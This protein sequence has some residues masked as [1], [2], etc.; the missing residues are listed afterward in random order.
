MP[1]RAYQPCD[2]TTS[3]PRGVT[4]GWWKKMLAFDIN[5]RG[6]TLVVTWGDCEGNQWQWRAVGERI[7]EGVK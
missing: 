3:L 7:M 1:L 2:Q 5:T 4:M 6:D